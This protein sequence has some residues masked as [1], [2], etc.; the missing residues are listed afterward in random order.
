[1][2]HSTIF[3]S[4]SREIRDF[5]R[6]ADHQISNYKRLATQAANRRLLDRFDGA[7]LFCASIDAIDPE[8]YLNIRHTAEAIFCDLNRLRKLNDKVWGSGDAEEAILHDIAQSIAKLE[9]TAT[10]LI[11]PKA[12]IINTNS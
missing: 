4:L 3:A 5:C 1:M 11:R 10:D 6:V 9:M 2:N 12:R 8:T 7:V